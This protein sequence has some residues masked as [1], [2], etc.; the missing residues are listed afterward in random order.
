[1]MLELMIFLVF[2][3]LAE[4]QRLDRFDSIRHRCFLRWNE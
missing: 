2:S 4:T 3:T 1:L